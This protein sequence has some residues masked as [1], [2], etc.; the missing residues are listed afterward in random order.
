MSDDRDE[1]RPRS[2]RGLAGQSNRSGHDGP[3]T[4]D[5]DTA[6]VTLVCCAP[7]AR[8]QASDQ[9]LRNG[10]QPGRHIGKSEVGDAQGIGMEYADV[11]GTDAEMKADFFG[12]E[13]DRF[14]CPHRL[15]PCEARI[16]IEA[17]WR[18][19]GDD[20]EPRPIYRSHRIKCQAAQIT[21]QAS[22][23]E[24]IHDELR[25]AQAN[26]LVRFN[27]PT[28]RDVC[29]TGGDSFTDQWQSEGRH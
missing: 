27:E 19:G 5:D 10:D 24:G 23:E 11:V 8:Q 28:P 9:R 3:A 20:R 29:I 25:V 18:V 12:H 16:R 6:V 1:P 4:H 13:R 21:R 2:Q 17:R 22:T 14:R 7:A 15:R 26:C